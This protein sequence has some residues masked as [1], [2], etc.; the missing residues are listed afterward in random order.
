MAS[1][2]DI[3]EAQRYNR[4]R[5]VTA[6]M[7]GT[8]GGRE[9]EAKASSR[10]LLIGAALSVLLVAV[11]AIMGRFAP[12]LPNGWQNN[13]VVVVKGTGTRYFTINGVLRPVTNLTSARLLAEADKFNVVEVDGSTLVGIPRG[14][15][16]GTTDAPDTVPPAENLR[17]GQWTACAAPTGETHTWVGGTPNQLA[18]ASVALVSNGPDLYLLANGKR[19]LVAPNDRDGVKIALHLESAAVHPVDAGFLALFQ[20][21]S[22]LVPLVVPGA[23][24]SAGQLPARL[25]MAT[26][27]TVVVVDEGTSPRRYLISAPGQITPLSPVAYALHSIGTGK[28]AGTISATVADIANLKVVDSAIVPADW[29]AQL[30]AGIAAGKL[31]CARLTPVDN[32][33][34]ATLAEVPAA[35]DSGAPLRVA[36]GSG[37]LVRSVSGGTLGAVS[38]ITDLGYAYGIDNPSDTLP[39]LG[40][41]TA[42]PVAIPQAWVALAPAGSM[43]S[44]KAT[45]ATVKVS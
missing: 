22:D 21:G 41:T 43:L 26:I 17:S 42:Q 10:P 1:N 19:F 11:A 20:R 3:L 6:F 23:G 34:V 31:A 30:S 44:S 13:T 38:I 15:E 37:A 40:Y 24:Q 29:P 35:S 2:K 33:A 36:G 25:S 7:S 9:L 39:R 5:L 4:R 28:V 18:D 32:G 14:S 27:G 12:T 8:P 45:W 16:V